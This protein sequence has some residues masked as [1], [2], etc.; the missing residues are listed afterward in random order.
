MSR[1]AAEVAAGA[2][3]LVLAA[4]FAL[5]AA[6]GAGLTGGGATYPLKASFRSLEGIAPGADVR[7]AGV[8]IGTIT[9]IALNPQTFLADAEVAIRQGIE[10]PTDT[11]ILISSEGLLGGNYVEVVPGGALEN[12]APG[13]EIEDTQGAV[14][15]VSLLMKFVGGSG[16]ETTGTDG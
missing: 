14:S 4:G 12:L 11:A 9:D 15:L 1:Y 10:L 6:N 2:A 13:A 5:Y 8:K 16:E 3:V 7:L